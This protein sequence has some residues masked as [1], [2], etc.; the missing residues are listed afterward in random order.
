M[1]A[2]AEGRPD[3]EFEGDLYPVPAHELAHH[4]RLEGPL[5][6][7]GVPDRFEVRQVRDETRIQLGMLGGEWSQ[8]AR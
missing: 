2:A 7:H 4:A 3:P 6:E 5:D 8:R 1:V